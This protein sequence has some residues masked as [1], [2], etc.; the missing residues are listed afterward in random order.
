LGMKLK[1]SRLRDDWTHL[2]ATDDSDEE[3]CVDV[4][5]EQQIVLKVSEE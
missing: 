1:K 3:V 2:V 4:I 5:I